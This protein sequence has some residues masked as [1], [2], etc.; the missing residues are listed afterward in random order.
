MGDYLSQEVFL[1]YE[2]L[3]VTGDQ[4]CFDTAE[5]SGTFSGHVSFRTGKKPR[6]TRGSG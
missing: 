5:E 4:F 3:K 1:T 2:D 6:R